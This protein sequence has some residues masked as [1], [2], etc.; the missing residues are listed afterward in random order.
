MSNKLELP[1]CPICG[2]Q[3]Y[4]CHDEWGRTM[5][6]IHCKNCGINIGGPPNEKTI[7]EF[8]AL[9]NFLKERHYSSYFL[10]NGEKIEIKNKNQRNWF[11]YSIGMVR[12]YK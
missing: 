12:I 1:I 2:A 5:F 11:D 8:L 4:G 3:T 7:E 9:A 6:H 10:K